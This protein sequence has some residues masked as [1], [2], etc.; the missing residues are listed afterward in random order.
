M[1]IIPI[2]QLKLKFEGG[3]SPRSS[4]YLDL[5]DTLSAL[6]VAY[7]KGNTSS[8]PESPELGDIYSNT[9]TGFIEIYTGETYEWEQVGGVA[10]IV[11]GVTATNT[12]VSRAYNNGAASVAFTPGT[13]L[14]RTYTVTSSPGSYTASGTTSPIVVTGL[15]SSTSY[16]YTVVSNNLYRTS[17]ASSP[18]SSVTATTVPEAPTIGTATTGN[19]SATVTYTPGATG[20]AS[21][22]YTATSSPGGF[23]GTG[24][25]P[26]TVSGLTNGTSYTFTV[27]ATNDNGTSTASSASNSVTPTSVS[28]VTGGTL[29]SDDT[30]FY[31]TFTS[32]ANLQVSSAPLT[33]DVMVISGGGGGSGGA[34]GF[35]VFTNQ[36]L[37][38]TITATIGAGSGSS[39]SNSSFGGLST[40][41]GGGTE[42]IGGSGGGGGRDGGIGA[43]GTAGQGN[44]GGNGG[45][46]GYG[47]AGGGGGAGA[48]GG[49]GVGG[50]G[51]TGERGGV[52]GVG[53]SAYSSWGA[54][55]GT[56]ENI[57]GTRYYAG[58]GGGFVQLASGGIPGEGGYGGGGKP[59]TGRNGVAN[60]GGGGGSIGGSG[61]VIVRYLK[62]AV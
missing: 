61:L 11:T 52:G 20:G 23:T 59:Q 26:I 45:T 60:T 29:A 54:A 19:A 44:K 49:N 1:P 25:S 17:S 22:T 24:T 36:S 58:G 21:A 53:T 43:V 12:P 42:V 13:I 35:T 16:T 2:E 56:G 27:T 3:D 6:P 38:G 57:G 48:A 33:A 10:S 18:S 32:T 34:G 14:G 28:I 46:G 47:G 50:A 8:R 37:S 62:T 5:I 55:T 41:G 7:A 30:Y 9:E 15:Q 4:D 40:L 39:G 51:A 31:R